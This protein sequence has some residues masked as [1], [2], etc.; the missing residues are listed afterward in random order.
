MSGKHIYRIVVIRT[1][2]QY[3][4]LNVFEEGLI[5]GWENMGMIVTSIY[6]SFRKEDL[7]CDFVFVMNG[8]LFDNDKS[9][10]DTYFRMPVYAY[11]VDHPLH[12]HF[13]IKKSNAQ[14][15]IMSDGDFKSYIDRHYQLSNEAE[16]IM[17]GGVE[18]MNS[19]RPLSERRH[20][21]VLCGTYMDYH[22]ILEKINGYEKSFQNFL[23]FMI[24]V[25]LKNPAFNIEEIFDRALEQFQLPLNEEEYTEF[26]WEC[27][28]VELYLR[29]YYRAMVVKQLVDAGISVEIYGN[30]WDKF[31]CDR[32]EFLHCNESIDF[33]ETLDVFADSK[34]VINVM[35]WARAGFHDRVACAML[36]GALVLTDET[37]YMREQQLDGEKLVTYSLSELQEIPQKVVY[38]LEHLDEAARIAKNGYEWAKENHTWEKCA[39]KFLE[40]FEK[41]Q[42]GNVEI[43]EN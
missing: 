25:G 15:C 38:Y 32:K 11:Y 31:D 21:V 5:R 1:V 18:G 33:Q 35:A 3:N 29:G 23:Y 14:H 41:G 17:H 26:L 42:S 4:A 39:E 36:N 7:D 2:S 28:D 27:Q 34:I 40:I 16:V 20:S 22:A 10:L 12:H 6:N 9:L 24:E 13:R 37:S 19:K 43:E 30:G 8:G